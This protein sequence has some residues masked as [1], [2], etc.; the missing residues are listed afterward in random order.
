MATR[1]WLGNAIDI[2]QKNTVTI[3]NTWATSDTAT[4]TINGKSL[5]VTIGSLVTTA[6][7]A[8]TIQQA[9][10]GISFTDTTASVTPTDGKDDFP[11]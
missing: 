10:E 4:L 1:T 6:Q 8:T 7:V 11:E 5:V 2:A 3:A 9:V